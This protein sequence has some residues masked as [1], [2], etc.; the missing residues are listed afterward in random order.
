MTLND[1]DI[2]ITT[3]DRPYVVKRL[4]DSIRIYYPD[5]DIY[6]G[7]QSKETK[8]FDEVKQVFDLPYD[9]GLSYARNYMFDNTP[10]PL[11]LLLDDDYVFTNSTIIENLLTLKEYFDIVGGA[12]LEKHGYRKFEYNF[13][14]KG[15][16]L[17]AYTISYKYAY[18]DE[19]PYQICDSVMNFGL[20]PKDVQRWDE[21]L[22]LAEHMD[23]FYRYQGKVCYT[24]SVIVF[25]D[26]FK[27]PEYLALRQR[28]MYYR[29]K[30]K[31][32]HGL[33]EIKEH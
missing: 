17:N 18:I 11:K 4:I 19:V 7:D 2:I 23:Y 3:I 26:S 1:I 30:F 33:D 20:F 9:C 14:R 16:V 22:K 10:K 32:K 27:P 31:E 13:E 5:I 21:N 12:V 24:P 15:N 28:G 29:E 8:S 25:H 6:V